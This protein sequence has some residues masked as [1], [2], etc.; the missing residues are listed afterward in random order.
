MKIKREK[1]L[2]PVQNSFKIK[3]YSVPTFQMAFHVH[4]DYE[5][6]CILK[7]KGKR[8]VGQTVEKFTAGDMIFVGPNLGHMW[9]SETTDVDGGAEA[10]VL[11]FNGELF[12]SMIDT[13]EF[14]TIKELFSRA[15]WG[16]KIEGKDRDRVCDKMHQ[17]L[18]H[19]GADLFITLIEI[20]KILSQSDHYKILNSVAQ[21]SEKKYKDKRID[22][23]FHYV[24][25][26]Y[27]E[28]I[29]LE[30]AA[31]IAN[32]EK[33]SFCRFF[34]GKTNKTFLQFLNET[35]IDKVCEELLKEDRT[36]SQIA[37][38]CGYNNLSNFYRQFK[39]VTGTTP[40]DY[41]NH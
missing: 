34:K 5:L 21:K 15:D 6:V 26:C 33:S 24:R 37:Y 17:L 36:I 30:K 29:S 23:L 41:R 10:I 20:L 38:A 31:A 39:K 25:A 28:T 16:I 27:H 18:I 2:Y 14:R 13:P 1:I 7:G 19:A 11:Q 22:A 32:M 12:Q 35:R 8:Y 4:P 9:R 3:K 40:G